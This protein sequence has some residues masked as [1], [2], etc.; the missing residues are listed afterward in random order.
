MMI[1]P[2]DLVTY[3]SIYIVSEFAGF[4]TVLSEY[5]EAIPWAEEEE[6]EEEEE[7]T[8][9]LAH[10]HL[11]SIGV[12]EM[13]KRLPIKDL[14]AFKKYCSGSCT[15]FPRAL[16][17]EQGEMKDL[18]SRML[19]E[20][21]TQGKDYTDLSKESLYYAGHGCLDVLLQCFIQATM[22]DFGSKSDEEQGLLMA[23][24]ARQSDC[25]HWIL[26]I[27]IDRQIGDDFVKIWAYQ[28]ELFSL[29]MTLGGCKGCRGL[30]RKTTEEGISQTILTL[31]L[32]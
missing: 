13:L 21:A 25:L 16:M 18:V 26:D 4:S 15:R 30:D 3:T 20:N 8:S 17:R 2:C 19:R 23:Q 1:A 10:L 24:I 6:E 14:A 7:V 31:P 12:G 11:E 28:K 32:K 27:L 22:P 29:H 5:L 9:L